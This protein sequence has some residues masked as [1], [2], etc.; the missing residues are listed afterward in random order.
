MIYYQNILNKFREEYKGSPLNI[1]CMGGGISMGDLLKLPG[2]TKFVKEFICLNNKDSIQYYGGGLQEGFTYGC[3]LETTKAFA[4]PRAD[5]NYV[6]I[7]A[8]LT[9]DRIRKGE[10]RAYVSICGTYWKLDFEK[11]SDLA[12]N[13]A[14]IGRRIQED[15]YITYFILNRL[16]NLEPEKEYFVKGWE[17]C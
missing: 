2:S 12:Y 8:A 6:I 5:N 13:G 15:E 9:T 3:N 4:F 16:L 10:N 11:L 14:F 1:V 17:Q 7:N